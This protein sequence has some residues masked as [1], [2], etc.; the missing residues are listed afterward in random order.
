LNG[1][2]NRRVHTAKSDWVVIGFGGE[3]RDVGGRAGVEIMRQEKRRETVDLEQTGI[4]PGTQMDA[5]ARAGE[6]DGEPGAQI[7]GADDGDT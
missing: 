4:A 3:E 1:G 5:V 2:E 7:A 6:V